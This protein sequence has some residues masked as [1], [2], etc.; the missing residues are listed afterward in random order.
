MTGFEDRGRGGPKGGEGPKGNGPE[1]GDISE[2]TAET[3]RK[4]MD[5]V[6][7]RPEEVLER[8]GE[9]LGKKISRTNEDFT[10]LVETGGPGVVVSLAPKMVI[11]VGKIADG[12]EPIDPESGK[13][14][15]DWQGNPREGTG[16]VWKNPVDNKPQFVAG[17][18]NGVI[19]INEA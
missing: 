8:L 2:L 9:V 16:V 15:L 5:I 4:S 10:Q 3:A 7:V 12:T 14:V 19:I 11:P 6:L 17:D 1:G 13:P 18:G